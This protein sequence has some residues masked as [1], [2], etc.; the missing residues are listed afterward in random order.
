M[1]DSFGIR[2]LTRTKAPKV[3]F[4][5]MKNKILG[6]KYS[7]SLVFIGE[8][9]SRT[10]NKKHRNKDKVADILSFPL[11]SSSGE[12]FI[13]LK[14]AKAESKKFNKTYT[15]FVGYLAI[16]GMLHLKGLSHGSKMD[17]AERKLSK[18]FHV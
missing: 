7:L 5:D 16:H 2:N 12:I 6:K 9:R 14:K 15:N 4:I 13:T 10:L 17:E 3:P 8:D 18:F 1:E 11:S